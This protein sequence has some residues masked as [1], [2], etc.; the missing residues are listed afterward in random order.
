VLH[1][2]EDQVGTSLDA[3]GRGSVGRTPVCLMEMEESPA[4]NLHAAVDDFNWT[5]CTGFMM[6]V[7]RWLHEHF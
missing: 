3:A 4:F 6:G 7:I 5:V 2:N 1:K